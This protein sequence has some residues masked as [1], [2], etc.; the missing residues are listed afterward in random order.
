MELAC[1]K[2]KMDS[3]FTL[4]IENKFQKAWNFQCRKAKF[5]NS[6]S[7]Y[8]RVSFRFSVMS[9]KWRVD[10]TEITNKISDDCGLM[11]GVCRQVFL[12]HTAV[13]LGVHRAVFHWA[14][15]DM[16]Y[17]V[18]PSYPRALGPPWLLCIYLTEEGRK[19]TGNHTGGFRG[20]AWKWDT[21]LL[22][23]PH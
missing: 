14:I 5:Y 16:F 3:F 18:A 12:T 1:Q 20:Q 2:E 7:K 23:A 9:G 19:S 15:Q 21:L 11:Q 22:L 17:L 8:G 4:F 6:K 10:S 13:Q